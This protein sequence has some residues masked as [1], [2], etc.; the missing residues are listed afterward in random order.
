MRE[1]SVK[2]E[3]HYGTA[4]EVRKELVEYLKNLK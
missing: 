4:E 1:W 2:R 3:Y